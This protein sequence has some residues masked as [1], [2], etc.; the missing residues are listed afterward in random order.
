MANYLQG[1]VVIVVGAGNEVHRGVAVALAEAGAD[2]AIAGRAPDLAAEAALHSIANEVWAIGRR[3]LVV[4]FNN[5]TEF[6]T[7]RDKV[8]AELGGSDFVVRCDVADAPEFRPS[9]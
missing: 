8:A 3:S 2:V 6:E 4:T 7:A 1:K 9:Y 5:E